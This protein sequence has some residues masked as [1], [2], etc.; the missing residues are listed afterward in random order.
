M[1][2]QNKLTAEAALSKIKTILGWD[3]DLRR[4]IISLPKINSSPGQKESRL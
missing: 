1:A 4:L 3:W 2:S